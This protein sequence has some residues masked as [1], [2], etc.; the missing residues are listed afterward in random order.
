MTPSIMRGL[1]ILGLEEMINLSIIITEI[2]ITKIIVYV[3]K[4]QGQVRLNLV[5]GP[6]RNIYLLLKNDYENLNM[7]GSLS[8]IA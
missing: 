1:S 8:T 5:S 4:H 6:L 2:A 3:S 7:R